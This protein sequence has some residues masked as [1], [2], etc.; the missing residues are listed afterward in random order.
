MNANQMTI[1]V[2][3]LDAVLAQAAAAGYTPQ[4]CAAGEE[5][6]L[7]GWRVRHPEGRFDGAKRFHLEEH[8]P[9]CASIR[10][11]SRS[12][13]NTQ[14]AHG[15]SA[16]HVAHLYG[17]CSKRTGRIVWAAKIA[18][19]SGAQMSNHERIE[20]HGKIAATL[21][22]KSERRRARRTQNA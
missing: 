9:D 3:G 8:C 1:T 15:R 17:V 22:P 12:W 2:A 16:R 5:A 7:R 14:N 4:E 21:V 11:P 18:L 13:P 10:A 20:L 6:A 19:R